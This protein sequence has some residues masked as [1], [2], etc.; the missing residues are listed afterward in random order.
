MHTMKHAHG[1][2]HQSATKIGEGWW[3]TRSDLIVTIHYAGTVTKKGLYRL[4][5]D[6]L[7]LNIVT[8]I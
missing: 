7:N 6:V 2:C 4:N 1:K 8:K 3:R 5:E